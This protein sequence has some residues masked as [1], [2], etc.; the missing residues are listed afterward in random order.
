MTADAGVRVH[1]GC[2]MMCLGGHSMSYCVYRMPRWCCDEARVSFRCIVIQLV[3]DGCAISS[4]CVPVSLG[5]PYDALC[6]FFVWCCLQVSDADVWRARDCLRFVMMLTYR[7]CLLG[8]YDVQVCA[9]GFRMLPCGA[10]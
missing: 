10:Y 2:Q 8:A 9:Y 3:A 7:D 1:C 6:L 5:R 4:W